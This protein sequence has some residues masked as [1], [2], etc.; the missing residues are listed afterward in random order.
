M[1]EPS[2]M[3]EIQTNDGRQLTVQGKLGTGSY[4]DVYKA[5]LYRASTTPNVAERV[6]VKWGRGPKT[7]KGEAALSREYRLV[8]SCAHPNIVKVVEWFDAADFQLHMGT[9]FVVRGSAIAFERAACSVWDMMVKAR[10]STPANGGSAS[11]P[12]SPCLAVSWAADVGSAL[13]YLHGR[14]IIH[15]D[16]KPANLLIFWDPTDAMGR[17][18]VQ[19]TAKLA[20]FGLA[21]AMPESDPSLKK[22]RLMSKHP[23]PH[24]AT[25][26]P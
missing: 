18:Y 1:S 13:S 9:P 5:I 23:S 22:R 11:T 14:R 2:R 24:A 20:D 16:V 21:R 19:T 12:V 7:P 3:C 10:A 25:S 6:A 26:T 4:G 17:G 8:R 15:R